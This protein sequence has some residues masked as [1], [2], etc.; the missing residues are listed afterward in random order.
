[1]QCTKWQFLAWI[2][3]MLAC[4]PVRSAAPEVEAQRPAD[5]QEQI[6]KSLQMHFQ[7]C[8]AEDMD[9]LLATMSKDLPNKDLVVGEL[10]SRWSVDE[11]YVKLESVEL[12]DDSDAPQAILEYPYATVLVTQT[13]I[14]LHADDERIPVFR[15][16]AR[17]P[18]CDPVALAN[19]M[20]LARLVVTTRIQLLF[21]HEDGEWR[22]VRGL[23][24][25]EAAGDTTGSD[26]LL[27]V[28][29]PSQVRARES[30][31]VFK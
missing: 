24:K 11:T 8:N 28:G 29:V 12:L 31:S 3:V 22:F 18:G 15:R 4:G 23:T 16:K 9:K 20:G 21:K 6:T 1:M 19:E 7:A 30:N 13:V 2:L 26:G 27:G 25:P 10:E 5:A 14:E 17:K